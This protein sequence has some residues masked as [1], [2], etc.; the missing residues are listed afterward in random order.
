MNNTKSKN[1]NIKLKINNKG[2][3]LV[4]TM[5]AMALA[6]IVITA[7][8]SLSI[9]TL[10]ASQQSKYLLEG[11]KLANQE[12]ELV[13]A[14]KENAASWT[15]F[16]T[17]ITSCTVNCYINPSTLAVVTSAKETLVADAEL[18]R[19]FYVTHPLGIPSAISDQIVRISVV[20][21][22]RVGPNTRYAHTYTDISNW[23]GN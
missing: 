6:V 14:S 8:V 16:M 4:E 23:A 5:L 22:W 7:L 2:F 10:R 9:F 1:K 3:G 18:T 17:S 21:S 11:S 20:V 15:A 12:L 19:H 13:R